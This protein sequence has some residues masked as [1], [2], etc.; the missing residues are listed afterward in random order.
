MSFTHY[1]DLRSA[2]LLKKDQ[3]LVKK[4]KNW[5]EEKMLSALVRNTELCKNF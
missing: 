3:I 5:N 1:G 2:K 4:N